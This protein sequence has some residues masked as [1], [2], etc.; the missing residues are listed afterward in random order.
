LV[1]SVFQFLAAHRRSSL[2]LGPISAASL[3]R[4]CAERTLTCVVEVGVCRTGLFTLAC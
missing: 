2:R 3:D 4:L 1:G